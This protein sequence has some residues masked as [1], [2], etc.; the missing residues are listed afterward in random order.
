MNI[1]ITVYRVGND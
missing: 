1:K